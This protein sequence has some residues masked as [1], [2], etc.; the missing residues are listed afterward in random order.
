MKTCTSQPIPA[1]PRSKLRSTTDP[2]KPTKNP[3]YRELVGSIM[4]AAL[5]TRP[6]IAHAVS[7]LSQFNERPTE[8]LWGAV[9]RVLRYLKGHPDLDSSIINQTSKSL[10]TP[11]QI[12]EMIPLIQGRIQGICLQW[13]ELQSPGNR[14]NSEPWPYQRWR[15]NIRHSP[16]RRKSPWIYEDLSA[17]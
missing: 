3:R 1:S 5:A 6:D 12:E 7:V 16:K 9:K 8:E 17:S 2:N 15:P 4:Y 13:Q 14:G 11:T 10:G